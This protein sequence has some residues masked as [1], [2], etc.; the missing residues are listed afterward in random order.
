MMETGGPEHT[1]AKGGTSSGA[2]ADGIVCIK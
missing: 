1:D 2:E